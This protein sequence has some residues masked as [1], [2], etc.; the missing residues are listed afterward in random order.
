MNPRALIVILVLIAVSLAATLWIGKSSL[1]EDSKTTKRF[2]KESS[3]ELDE[4]APFP[5][6]TADELE[7][8]FTE[9]ELGTNGEHTF[10]I[11]NTGE[12]ILKLEKGGSTCKC[13]LSNLE[14]PEIAPGES[15][16]IKLEWT[17]KAESEQF[18]QS[19]TIFTND[20]E[21]SVLDFLISG[22]VLKPIEIL[23]LN[24]VNAGNI[25][26]NIGATARTLFISKTREKL[27]PPTVKYE[28]DKLTFD[29]VPLEASVR[30]E[31]QAKAGYAIE[32]HVS[33]TI[34]VGA[35]RDEYAIEYTFDGEQKSIT[36]IV[37]AQRRGPIDFHNPPGT[38][39]DKDLQLL[40][41][42]RFAA[43][44]GKEA[45][46]TLFIDKLESGEKIEI[47]SIECEKVPGLKLS[48]V[49][50]TELDIPTRA[51][52]DILVEMPPDHAP[53]DVPPNRNTK[54]VVKTNHPLVKEVSILVE[55]R[56][57]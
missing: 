40:K 22:R 51:A 26:E 37:S 27:D 31:N 4:E 8:H 9:M 7:H 38:K 46:L 52:F 48:A 3:L 41:L 39:F 23:P 2:S 44:Q 21:H 56:S 20:P 42:G 10:V 16:E 54:I 53:V 35:F 12:D 25:E 18:S 57:F 13:T 17:P 33:S 55:L 29:I 30:D 32:S 49:E 34:P 36:Q 45:R 1:P 28:G 19:A 5:I 24:E 47:T 43:K 50:N 11:R 14:H 6:A 15:V